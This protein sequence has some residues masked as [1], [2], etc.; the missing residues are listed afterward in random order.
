M[1]PSTNKISKPRP[2]PIYHRWWMEFSN[3]GRHRSMHERENC[4]NQ[5][6]KPHNKQPKSTTTHS[7]T[8]ICKRNHLWIARDGDLF[9]EE[10]DW[11]WRFD[12]KGREREGRAWSGWGEIVS[13][14]ERNEFKIG[15]NLVCWWIGLNKCIETLFIC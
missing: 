10:L 6:K 8:Q 5:P 14:E 9:K 2:L 4:K 12:S 15:W 7:L 1:N 11:P 13:E 3:P